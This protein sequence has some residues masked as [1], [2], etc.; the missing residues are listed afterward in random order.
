MLANLSAEVRECLWHAEE[1]AERGKI[2]PNPA[3]RRDFIEMEGRWLKLARSYQSL[4]RLRTFSAHQEQ[5]R[6]GL[7]DRLEQLKHK[8]AASG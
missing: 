7:S 8:L 6:G 4:E 3:T 5:R 1:C 2:E